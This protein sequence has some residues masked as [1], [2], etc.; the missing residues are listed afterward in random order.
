[1]QNIVLNDENESS[2]LSSSKNSP[3]MIKNSALVNINPNTKT[4]ISK[5]TI[6]N[7]EPTLSKRRQFRLES[8]V[9]KNSVSGSDGMTPIHNNNINISNIPAIR[10]SKDNNTSTFNNQNT[11]NSPEV[12]EF[13]KKVANFAIEEPTFY[14]KQ[15]LYS[16]EDDF[17]ISHPP[18][19]FTENTTPINSN[20]FLN[21]N[22]PTTGPNNNNLY[23][24]SNN[25]L[26]NT[27]NPNKNAIYGRRAHFSNDLDL[28]AG[29]YSDDPYDTRE[30]RRELSKSLMNPNNSR[31]KGK[32]GKAP[33]HQKK[34]YLEQSLEEWRNKS[35]QDLFLSR[36]DMNTI[37]WNEIV[38]RLIHI[39][40][41]EVSKSRKPNKNN[42]LLDHLTIA[43]RIMRKENY[44]LA[45]VNKDL[46]DI[47]IPIPILKK[48]KNFTQILEWN[49]SFCLFYYVFDENNRLKRRFLRESNKKV[50][51]EGYTKHH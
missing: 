6:S 20:R 28:E 35:F 30:S 43:N 27:P 42:M 13:S 38:N 36:A 22:F 16:E 9:R 49:L 18:S 50:L 24:N 7:I 29:I 33:S 14:K 15:Q 32:A 31:R 44:L 34:S 47:S 51:S 11:Y 48:F 39:R 37:T 3:R 25:N 1:M 2:G 45:L 21:S 8:R 12:A 40:E 41:I 5:K 4:A 19:I 23:L 26:K 46:I 17:D 10:L